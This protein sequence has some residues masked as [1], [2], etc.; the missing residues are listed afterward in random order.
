MAAPLPFQLAAL[1]GTSLK[2][3]TFVILGVERGGAGPPLRGHLR[4]RPRHRG[5]GVGLVAAGA[6]R[7][8]QRDERRVPGPRVPRHPPARRPDARAAHPRVRRLVGAL[9]RVVHRLSLGARRH[10]VRGTGPRASPLLLHPR[11]A[12][13]AFGGGAAAHLLQ[14]LLLPLGALPEAQGNR[15]RTRCPSGCTC[16]SPASSSSR[17]SA[18]TRRCQS[19]LS[20]RSS[21]GLRR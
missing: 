6:E 10:E 5:A 13:P 14:P 11:V 9:P 19:A 17:S 7:A 18:P 2:R 12:R 1:R 15:P 3:A 4:P 16:R 21:C 20:L 8:A